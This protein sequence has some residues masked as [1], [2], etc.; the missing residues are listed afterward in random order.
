MTR[1]GA[2]APRCLVARTVGFERLE[3]RSLLSTFPAAFG[4]QLVGVASESAFVSPAVSRATNASPAEIDTGDVIGEITLS[5][6]VT[7]LALTSDSTP[8]SGRYP[9][10][11]DDTFG[12]LAPPTSSPTMSVTV[13]LLPSGATVSDGEYRVGATDLSSE[14][15]FALLDDM[16]DSGQETMRLSVSGDNEILLVN[17]L[18][19]PS[20]E[21]SAPVVRS[22]RLGPLST[23]HSNGSA[24]FAAN[25]AN[26]SSA[27]ASFS[28]TAIV[29]GSDSLVFATSAATNVSAGTGDLLATDP[30]LN[31][32]ATGL[33]Q[34]ESFLD[35]HQPRNRRTVALTAAALPCSVEPWGL[36]GLLAPSP[37][38]FDLIDFVPLDEGA[39]GQ[40]IDRFL[41]QVEEIGADLSWLQ[42][43]TD[44]VVELMALALVLKAV[45]KVLEH[46]HDH[47]DQAT[48]DVAASLEGISG[49]PGGSSPEEA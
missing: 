38:R 1:R 40:T 18:A 35:F 19:A 22:M 3:D 17:G 21:M 28:N 42:G 15:I 13:I 4:P 41:Q 24:E 46:F 29:A 23:E 25:G 5:T 9:G 32:A 43:A 27:G 31:L 10:G 36:F 33:E 6:G 26:S 49:L 14:K 39:L 30:I 16:A 8:A 37:Q 2:C 45:S 20:G 11:V 48:V 44:V 34:I 12:L 47:D 7:T